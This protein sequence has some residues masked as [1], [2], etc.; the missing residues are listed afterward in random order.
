[1]KWFKCVLALIVVLGSVT[2]DVAS[3]DRG[4]RSRHHSHSS[5]GLH[6]GVPLFWNWPSPYYGYPSPYYAYPPGYAYPPSYAYPAP[7][8]PP[9]YIERGDDEAAPSRDQGYWYY[10]DRPEGYYPY[11]KECPGGWERVSPTPSR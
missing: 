7:S 8:S 10:C 2:P 9:V 1:M 5:I 6:F 11:V 3:A 4:R